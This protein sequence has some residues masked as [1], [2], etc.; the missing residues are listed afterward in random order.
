MIGS[1]ENE[2]VSINADEEVVLSAALV[3]L[4]GRNIASGG[5]PGIHT[6]AVAG[7]VGVTVASVPPFTE[8]RRFLEAAPGPGR[9]LPQC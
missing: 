2:P 7:E 5:V 1:R 4:I 6:V 3:M 9:N 8:A